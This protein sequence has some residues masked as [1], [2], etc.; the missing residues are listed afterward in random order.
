MPPDNAC[1]HF[2]LQA[3][4][5]S[6]LLDSECEST[7]NNLIYQT[8]CITWREEAIAAMAQVKDLVEKSN[9]TVVV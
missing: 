2:V 4:V 7:L 1:Q 6:G 5:A 3:L 8:N 9:I